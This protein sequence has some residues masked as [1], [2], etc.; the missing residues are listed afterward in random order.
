MSAQGH[1]NGYV[2]PN[3][4]DPN[5]SQEQAPHVHPYQHITNTSQRPNNHLRLR[6]VLRPRTICSPSLHN[7][8]RSPHLPNHPLP[9]PL[10]M[11][12]PH[13]PPPRIP[14]LHLPLPLRTPG[15]LLHHLVRATILLHRHRAC[16]PFSRNLRRTLRLDQHCREGV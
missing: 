3:W 9:N 5:G 10:P 7:L 12:P 8:P 4:P 2:D 1:P 15:P 14:R 16:L 11:H 13:R 6:P